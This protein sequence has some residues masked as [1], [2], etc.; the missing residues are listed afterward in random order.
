MQVE[1]IND[2]QTTDKLKSCSCMCIMKKLYHTYH[3]SN[4]SYSI[5]IHIYMY[6]YVRYYCY[7]T[8]GPFTC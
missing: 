4:I 5:Y 3:T 7:L 1:F 6:V 8:M 2:E